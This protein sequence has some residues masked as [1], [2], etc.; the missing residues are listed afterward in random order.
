MSAYYTITKDDVNKPT[1]RAFGRVVTVGGFLGRILPGDVGKR[2]YQRDGVIQ[3][4]NEE[5]RD[6]RLERTV[7]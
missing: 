1:I 5:Q 7:Q 3:A 6:E 4:E 2:L